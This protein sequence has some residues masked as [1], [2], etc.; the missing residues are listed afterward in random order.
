MHLISRDLIDRILDDPDPVEA[1][2]EISQYIWPRDESEP[3]LGLSRPEMNFY[4]FLTY[5]AEIC[6]N[7]H[8]WFFLNPSG[9]QVNRILTALE[10]MELEGPRQILLKACSVFP[11]SRVPVSSEHRIDAIKALP[12]EETKALWDRLD[13]EYFGEWDVLCSVMS[14]VMNYLRDHRDEILKPETA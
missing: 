3:E 5:D 11:D 6:R 12:Y 2:G 13:R 7:G 9:G 8:T 10:E 14:Q 1:F 4:S